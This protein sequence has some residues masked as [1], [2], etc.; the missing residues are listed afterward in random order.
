[1]YTIISSYCMS[2]K[3]KIVL[4][5][6]LIVVAAS[7]SNP[8]CSSY[9]SNSVCIACYAGYYINSSNI[10]TVGSSYCK[11]FTTDATGN[12]ATCWDS[13]QSPPTCQASAPSAPVNPWCSTFSGTTCTSCYAGYY[14]NTNNICTAGNAYCKTF[15]NDGTG[16]CAQCWDSSHTGLTCSYTYVAPV[17]PYCTSYASNGACSTCVGGYHLN[18]QGVCT[19]SNQCP[20]TSGNN[21]A[22]TSCWVGYTLTNGACVLSANAA[23]D[24][25]CLSFI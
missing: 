21:S 9:T 4:L 25:Y 23:V 10:C 14:I 1:M 15:T 8:Y 17:D 6:T 5:V 12:C 24:P 22:C 7:Q 16:N 11:S 3:T 18:N 19:L 13:S 2:F 20:T